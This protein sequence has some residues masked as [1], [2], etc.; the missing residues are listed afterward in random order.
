MSAY[1]SAFILALAATP[2][3]EQSLSS[4]M[5]QPVP[6]ANK[7]GW[8]E[9]D[10]R[11]YTIEFPSAPKA[12]ESNEGW[13]VVNRELRLKQKD[14]V[15]VSSY[16]NIPAG[17]FTPIFG[18]SKAS[19]ADKVVEGIVRDSKARVYKIDKGSRNQFLRTYCYEL[20]SGKY[21]TGAII[22]IGGYCYQFSVIYPKGFTD[23][24]ELRRFADSFKLKGRSSLPSPIIEKFN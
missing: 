13:G 17:A 2:T 16:F 3:P 19:L 6:A 18:H 9:M 5:A 24:K 10:T 12:T 1:L 20:K 22:F 11:F 4:E 23:K 8:V 7:T 21:I 15:F 14:L